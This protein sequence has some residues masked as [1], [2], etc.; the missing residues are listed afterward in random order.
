[1]LADAVYLNA[2]WATPFRRAATAPGTFHGPGANETVAF[3]HGSLD[4]RFLIR[5][6]LTA[7]ELPYTG[8]RLAAL[9]LEPTSASIGAYVGALRPSVLDAT[10]AAL[11]S[12]SVELAIP[13]LALHSAESLQGVLAELGMG[14]AFTDGADLSGITASPR[15]KVAVVRQVATLNL[16]EAGTTAA[17]A[18]GVGIIATALPAARAVIDIDRPF[19]LLVRDRSSG[20]VVF[21][22]VVVRP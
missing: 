2:K 20:A 14:L 6:G 10:V 8:G 22:A 9:V 4:A 16:D 21:E 7:V 1:V 12:G 15:L 11:S 17:A 18:T 3:L 5:P 13:K 19:V